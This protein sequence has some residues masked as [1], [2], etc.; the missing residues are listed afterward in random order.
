VRE[1]ALRNHIAL[2]AFRAGKGNGSLL[3]ELVKA[4][5]L[6]WYL[7]EAGFGAFERE[8]Y[9]NAE[10]ILDRAARNASADIWFIT[11]DDIPPITQLLDL[12]V[13]QLLGAPIHAVDK[14]RA[15]L[16]WFAKT[17]KRSPW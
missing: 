5:Y 3:A 10:R 6:A 12:H 16:L 2:A 17:D 13:Q 11:A 9:L 7:Q 4:L 8:L 15:Q 1:L 14:A